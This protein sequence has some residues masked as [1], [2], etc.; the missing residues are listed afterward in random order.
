VLGQPSRCFPPT[1]FRSRR[2]SERRSLVA[3]RRRSDQSKLRSRSAAASETFAPFQSRD[4]LQST[5][6]GEEVPL[7]HFSTE[8]ELRKRARKKTFMSHSLSCDFK[9][10][11]THFPLSL[12][13]CSLL[14]RDYECEQTRKGVSERERGNRSKR[15]K[16]LF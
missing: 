6:K 10:S 11:Q 12:A 13:L 5:E 15:R 3:T 1:S 8:T 16:G 9:L 7:S 4:F 2:C 14:C